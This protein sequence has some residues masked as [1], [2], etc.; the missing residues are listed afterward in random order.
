MNVYI[1]NEKNYFLHADFY[2]SLSNV[3]ITRIVSEKEL[4]CLTQKI[5]NLPDEKIII[6]IQSELLYHYVDFLCN[7]N[8]FYTL[9]TISNDDFTIP[10]LNYPT[11]NEYYINQTNKLLENSGLLY[12]YS[13]NCCI[14]HD[15]IIPLPLGPKFQS[16]STDFFAESDG[17]KKNMHELYSVHCITPNY[18]FQEKKNIISSNNDYLL[19][20]YFSENT[21]EN[22][23]YQDH[24]H[25]R[26]KIYHFFEESM[27]DISH[28][29][30]NE[31][32][33]Q[34]LKKY[35]FAISPPGRG[36]DVHRTWEALMV[37]TIPIVLSSTLNKLY[38]NLPVLIV[39]NYEIIDINYL[40]YKY[41]EIHS[42]TYDFSILYGN[43][44]I[45]KIKSCNSYI[46]K[47][48][49]PYWSNYLQQF[50]IS[51]NYFQN[52]NLNTDKCCVIVDTRISKTLILVIKNFMYLLQNNGWG[53]I[54]FH[55]RKNEYFIKNNLQGLNIRYINLEV[56]HLDINSYS[57]LCINIKFWQ[58]LKSYGYIYAFIFQLDTLLF[59][60]NVDSFLIYDYIGAPWIC[61]RL[62]L[63]T[64][65]GGFSIRKIDSMI[66]ILT[67]C[68]LLKIYNDKLLPED[69]YFSYWCK[70][71]NF[72]LP[73]KEIA[74]TFSVE[75]IYDEDPCGIH[76]PSFNIFPN[77]E[78]FIHLFN[79]KYVI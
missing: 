3:Q 4:D 73:R 1:N 45:N 42:K 72:S 18:F 69:E 22:P 8:I 79:K 33:I 27:F 43:Y 14:F 7:L 59:K 6:F 63:E 35:K 60:N 56:D 29:Q 55:G 75:S 19:Y 71:L 20:I 26:K 36:I 41:D 9:I 40:L 47:I 78:A 28:Y 46:N 38:E 10:Y 77:Q 2:I 39:E 57:H 37:G 67:N 34:E 52:I 25:I 5:Y 13:K 51:N 66:Y 32:Y 61:S 62:N 50:D 76:N 65:N 58:I 68:P 12:W 70:E 54:I 16:L 30:S 74:K 64:G 21:T 53:L 17:F 31:V 24:Q 44:W 49:E 15:K 23:F 48:Y 11:K